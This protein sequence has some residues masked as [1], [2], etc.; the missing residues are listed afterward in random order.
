M[1]VWTPVTP[2]SAGAATSAKP[3]II[4]PLTTKSISP[5]GAAGPCPVQDL[6]VVAVVRLGLVGVALLDRARDGFADRTVPRSVGVLPRQAVLLARRADDALGVLV[7]AGR[8]V[9]RE[10][11]FVL[12][13]DVAAADL[14]G[15]ELVAADAPI[16]DLLAPGAGV[17]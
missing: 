3:P 10:R 1:K 14:D 9:L 5:S 17:E 6:E 11:V 13:L 12:R 4:T 8:V 2:Y 15:V 7:D 16:E